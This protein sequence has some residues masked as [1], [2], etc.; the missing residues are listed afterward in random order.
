MVFDGVRAGLVRDVSVCLLLHPSPADLS[1][2]IL[3]SVLEPNDPSKI[4]VHLSV[5]A[6]PLCMCV[7]WYLPEMLVA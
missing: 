1:F 7:S 6:T 4:K 5:I 3:C 2:F